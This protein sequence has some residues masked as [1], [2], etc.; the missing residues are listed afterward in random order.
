MTEMGRIF[1][2][3]VFDFF[4]FFFDSELHSK[5]YWSRIFSSFFLSVTKIRTFRNQRILLNF[6]WKYIFSHKFDGNGSNF[7]NFDFLE[8]FFIE[9]KNQ[10]TPRER[11]FNFGTR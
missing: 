1:K 7:Q 5:I 3:S 2:I 8:F 9:Q 4:F 10:L 6:F 11:L